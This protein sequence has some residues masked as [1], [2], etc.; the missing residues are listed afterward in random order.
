MEEKFKRFLE[1]SLKFTKN[2]REVLGDYPQSNN[3]LLFSNPSIGFA[4]LNDTQ[5]YKVAE[6]STADLI[7]EEAEKKA[8]LAD[9]FE[10]YLELQKNLGEYFRITEKLNN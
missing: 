8:V 10:E 1:L 4:V 2:K 7:R 3:G 6:K 9:E 5:S